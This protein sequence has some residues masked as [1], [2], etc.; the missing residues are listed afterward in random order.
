VHAGSPGHVENGPRGAVFAGEA[1]RALAHEQGAGWLD[2][3]LRGVLQRWA[4]AL[5]PAAAPAPSARSSAAAP[6]APPAPSAE[7]SADGAAA[8][9][10]G[11]FAG[12]TGERL[13][14]REL[15]VVSLIARGQSNKLIARELALSPHTVKRHVANAL[16]KLAMATRGQAASWYHAQ[17]QAHPGAPRR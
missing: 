15:E 4:E 10:A 14:D 9:A 16:A 5:A 12:P 7:P 11:G 6:V 1:V 3:P 8:G 17:R 2:E 13:S